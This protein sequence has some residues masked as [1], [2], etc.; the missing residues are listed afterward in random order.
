MITIVKNISFYV[1]ISLV[2]CYASY[3]VQSKSLFQYLSDNIVGL[4]L[5][6]LAINTATSGLIASKMQD[7]VSTFP[8]FN[9]QDSIKQMKVSLLEQ[10]ILIIGSVIIIIMQGSPVLKFP[11]KDFTLDVLLV[12][13]MVY[14]IAVLWDTGKAVFI[15]IEEIQKMKKNNEQF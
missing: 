11:H 8:T 14:S 12:T 7:L 1:L 15:V 6:L 5:T 3:L 2:F 13:I 10:I 4:L 9:F